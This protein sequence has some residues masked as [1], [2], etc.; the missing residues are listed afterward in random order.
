MTSQAQ[1][2]IQINSRVSKGGERDFIVPGNSPLTRDNG[3]VF[4]ALD[5]VSV[6]QYLISLVSQISDSKVL[7]A[8]RISNGR[9]AAYLSSK[10]A[11][12]EVV[13]TG[14]TYDGTFIE[15]TPLVQPTTRLTL[16]NVY[17]EIPNT[18][19]IHNL[20]SFCKV[21]SQVRS[22]PLGFKEKHL[23]HIMSF[24]RQVHVLLKPNVTPPEHIN[25]SYLGTNYRVFL[26]TES[27]RCFSCGEYGHISRACKKQGTDDIDKNETNP[28]NPPPTFVHNPSN[29]KKSDPK[30]PPKVSK[31]PLGD[32][33]RAGPS[34]VRASAG[35]G[36]S[37]GPAGAACA[38]AGHAAPVQGD[39]STRGSP[40]S[41]AGFGVS[42]ARSG[43]G[44][45][46]SSSGAGGSAGAGGPAGPAG[47]S[48][49]AAILAP[50]A[51]AS[52]AAPPPSPLSH[53]SPTP[54][55]HSPSSS[56]PS[57]SLQSTH[58]PRNPVVPSG[59]RHHLLIDSFLKLSLRGNHRLNLL[60]QTNLLSHL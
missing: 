34:G 1:R 30:H 2:P 7:S 43:E 35:S 42:A 58:P 60:P 25:L 39:V 57:A 47:P 12:I 54:S 45:A 5:T 55:H 44:P 48:A 56:Q 6:R 16:S 59:D 38:G 26:S 11:V 10:E 17:P 23:S 8:S 21:V 9:I 33:D 22:I 19:L 31:P 41:G 18:V 32:A 4:K 51:P 3:I 52:S 13:Q 14:L 27:V 20:S 49:P 24:R 15:L 40:G 29:R 50:G 46:G 36:G 53:H 37:A 28:L